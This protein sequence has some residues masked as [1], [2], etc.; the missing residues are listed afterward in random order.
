MTK[1]I[2]YHGKTGCGK[3]ETAF[4]DFNP[5]THYVKS[6]NSKEADWW[7]GYTGQETVIIDEFRGQITYSE[8]LSLMD[9]WPKKVSRRCREPIPFL[10]KKIIITSSLPPEEVYVNLA[11]KDS[12]DQLLRR[13]EI[14]E[15]GAE[16]KCPMGN[17][18]PLDLEIHPTDEDW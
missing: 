5:D 6:V 12:L 14:V 15:I 9:G 8:L 10:A 11:E 4:K 3:S 16:Q 2:W 13:C 1:G 17:T 18:E 7:D